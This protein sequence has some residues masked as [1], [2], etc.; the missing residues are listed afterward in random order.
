M[1]AVKGV[2]STISGYLSIVSDF[3]G[4]V[5]QFLSPIFKVIGSIFTVMGELLRRSSAL[6]FLLGFYGLLLAFLWFLFSY[7]DKKRLTLPVVVFT[8]AFF[9]FLGGN[10]L[11]I[12]EDQ[13]AK[14][15]EPAAVTQTVG[16]E[17]ETAEAT[18]GNDISV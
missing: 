13:N 7:L 15:S 17:S 16:S 9:L 18:G 10:L 12:A 3:F 4:T 2:L 1:E 8:L 14:D 11:M 6:I 5:S